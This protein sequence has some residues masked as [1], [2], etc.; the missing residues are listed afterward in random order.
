MRFSLPK[1]PSRRFE[2]SSKGVGFGPPSRVHAGVSRVD[3]SRVEN[4]RGCRFS[5]TL[6]GF[7][8]ADPRALSDVTRSACGPQRLTDVYQLICR[9]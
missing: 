7:V 8:Q 6:F 1:G 2:A 3:L 5:R 4:R 9:L